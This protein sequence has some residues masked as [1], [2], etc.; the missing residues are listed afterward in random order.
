MGVAVTA[1]PWFISPID[2]EIRDLK[3]VLAFEEEMRAEIAK[4][5]FSGPP[6][7]VIYDAFARKGYSD[8]LLLRLLDLR[9]AILR[10]KTDA[11]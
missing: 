3:A 10:E 4:R 6:E 2:A 11:A 1:G 8:G 5:A 7:R 9:E